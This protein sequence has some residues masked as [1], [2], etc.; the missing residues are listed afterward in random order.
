MPK[1]K[2][3]LVLALF[4]NL[5]AI[6]FNIESVRD[7]QGDE[8][9]KGQLI[10]VHFKGYLILDSLQMEEMRKRAMEDSLAALEFATP[11]TSTDSVTAD[12][13][14]AAPADTAK[15]AQDATKSKD[16][17]AATADGAK[18]SKV[19]VPAPTDSATAAGNIAATADSIARYK[20]KWLYI[21]T[22]GGE[23][24]EFTLG[25]GQVIQGWEKG[26]LGMKVGEIRY[27]TVPA[28][29]AYGERSMDGIPPNSDLFY[30]VELVH[31]D[32]PMEPDKFPQSVDA[33]KWKELSKGLKI[34]D[35]KMG[36]GNAAIPGS[37]LKTH[38]TGWLLSGRKFGSSKDLGK[39]F[40]VVLGAGKLIKGWEK[41]LEGMRVG[42]VR[43]LRVSPAM[44]YGAA[45]YTMIPSNS[46]LVFRVELM[47]SEVDSAVIEKMDFFPDTTTLALENGSEGLRYAIVKPGEGEPARVGTRVRVHYT[48]WLT[49]GHKFDSSRDRGQVLRV[50]LGSGQV[51]RGWDLG[52][53]GMLPGEKRI[54][55]VPPGLAYGSR[56]M[57]PIPGGSTLIFA[58]EYLGE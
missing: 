7:G 47:E 13:A 1:L 39:S 26:I 51:I 48:G 11:E 25:V 41:G 38:Y 17:K 19:A 9:R 5:W 44:G 28:V 54:L 35:E 46:T 49:N 20:D 14:K 22:Y 6:P 12:S 4:C 24:L 55:I 31:A 2:I 50:S 43:W 29:M 10:K 42:G 21:N 18:D 23:P 36:S 58:V 40:D 32:P 33:L 45:A 52:I 3:F 57:G 56:G 15:T 30:E 37:T 8:I 34:Y 16:S 53:A 27:L